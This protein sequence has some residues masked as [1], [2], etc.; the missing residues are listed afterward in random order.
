MCLA[1]DICQK[2]LCAFLDCQ[3]KNSLYR[4]KILVVFHRHLL[5]IWCT[6]SLPFDKN[7]LFYVT[8]YIFSNLLRHIS[9]I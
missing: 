9:L 8:K 3:A 4:L 1:H 7:F 5:T 2:N 6:I